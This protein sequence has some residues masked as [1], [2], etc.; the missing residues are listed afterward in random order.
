MQDGESWCTMVRF[1]AVGCRIL[2]VS[3][4]WWRLVKVG[5][6]WCRFKQDGAGRCIFLQVSSGWRRLVQDG[7]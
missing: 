5:D 2:Q 3:V 7:A 1:G 4:G 6:S